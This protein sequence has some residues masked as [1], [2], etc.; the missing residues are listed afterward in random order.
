MV[1]TCHFCP[2]TDDEMIKTLQP[3]RGRQV[4]FDDGSESVQDANM[5][6]KSIDSGISKN[7]KSDFLPSISQS[8]PLSTEATLATKISENRSNP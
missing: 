7:I 2:T 4:S 1:V 8:K 5:T 6:R 3:T